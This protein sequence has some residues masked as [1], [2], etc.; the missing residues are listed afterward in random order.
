MS[1]ALA[2]HGV[3]DRALRVARD[4]QAKGDDYFT[5]DSQGE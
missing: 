3:M 2:K 5:K 4:M 1:I